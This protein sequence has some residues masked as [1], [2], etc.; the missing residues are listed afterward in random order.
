MA[1]GTPASQCRLDDAVPQRAHGC[2]DRWNPALSAG[3]PRTGR[4]PAGTWRIKEGV[5]DGYVRPPPA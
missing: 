4:G 3:G 5:R 2:R 1:A